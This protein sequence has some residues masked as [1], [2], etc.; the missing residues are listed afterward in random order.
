MILLGVSPEDLAKLDPIL[1]S[2]PGFETP[3]VKLSIY[4]NRRGAYKGCFL[5]CKADLGTCRINPQ[6]LTSW[7]H[8]MLSIEDIKIIVDDGPAVWEK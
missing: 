3:N 6:F 7:H 2:N 5:W 4:K 1:A 8:E